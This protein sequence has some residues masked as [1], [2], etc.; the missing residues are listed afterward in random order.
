MR[1]YS[2]RREERENSTYVGRTG[3]RSEWM[4]AA[5]VCVREREEKEADVC[6]R[7]LT[8]VLFMCSLC[9]VYVQMEVS[10]ARATAQVRDGYT[11]L[12]YHR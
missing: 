2:N 11:R 7:L 8:N 3:I 4:A 1:S 9:R 10:A 5:C 6:V 12:H